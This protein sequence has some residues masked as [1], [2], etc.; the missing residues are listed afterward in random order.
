MQIVEFE[1]PYDPSL[2]IWPV[3]TRVRRC[4]GCC[5]SKLLH[6]VPTK[7]STITLKVIKARYPHP[8]AEMLEL[9]G[10]ENVRMEQHDRCACQCRQEERDCTSEQI[11][12]P[13]TCRCVCRNHHEAVRCKQPDHFWDMK[14]C[15]CK[16]RHHL[17]C[18]TGS[19]FNN[20]SCKEVLVKPSCT[21]IIRLQ[22]NT[23][24]IKTCESLNHAPPP[25][26]ER[27]PGPAPHLSTLLKD[28]GGENDA[29]RLRYTGVDPDSHVGPFALAHYKQDDRTY[30]IENVTVPQWTKTESFG[31]LC[32]NAVRC[33]AKFED[34][35][36]KKSQSPFPFEIICREKF[37]T[38]VDVKL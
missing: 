1:R 31:F 15:T 3:C 25:L 24:A 7:T 11:Y 32:T 26:L 19:V 33:K 10:Y 9:E 35:S 17:E 12:Q 38:M 28:D 20:S 30:I 27:V 34:Q 22:T 13:A 36:Q 37:S 18:S 2:V 16:C 14:D 4:G 8:G 21:E 23:F 6:C 29:Y 5:S